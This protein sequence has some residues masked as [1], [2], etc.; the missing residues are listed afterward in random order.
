MT[1][2]FVGKGRHQR[3]H[4]EMHRLHTEDE[5]YP[6][7]SAHRDAS[8]PHRRCTLP[9]CFGTQRC[10]DS[11]PKMSP[12]PLLRHTEMHRLHTEDAP[13]PIASAHRDALALHRRCTLPHCFGTQRCT[14]STPKMHPTPL[15][16]HTEMHLLSSDDAP[17]PIALAHR[18]AFTQQRR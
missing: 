9:H 4:T 5:P 17:Y 8:T 11:T 10:I 7:A 6:I 12:T 1:S 14:G 16:R 18:D 2:S 3:R 15:L 13:Y